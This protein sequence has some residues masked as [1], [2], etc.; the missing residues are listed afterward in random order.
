MTKIAVLDDWQHLA[1]SATD[2]SAVKAQAQVDF[3]YEPL[4]TG[5]DLAANLAGYDI[6]VA[7]RERARFDKT[8]IDAMTDLKLLSYTGPRNASVDLDACT[9]RGITVCNTNSFPLA[10]YDTAELALGHILALSRQI[11]LGDSEIRAGRF[12]SNMPTGLGLNQSVLGVIG[13]GRLGARLA[14]YALALEMKVIGWSPNLTAARAE[15][16]GVTL[17]TKEE[18]MAQSDVISI[19]MV[20]SDRS[21]GIV[22][23]ADIARMKPGAILV[24]T[25]RGP[26]VDEPALLEALN[27]RRIYAGLDVFAE[28]PL[29]VDHPLRSTPNT[30]LTPHLGYTT[31]RNMAYLYSQS[32]ENLLAW[33]AGKPI[34]VAN[35]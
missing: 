15:E 25:S 34:R 20:L 27:A 17:V 30:L 26:L 33:L 7:M 23:A 21:R 22:G 31:E 10:M 16:A 24:N 1:E 6:V 5:T 29:P 9:A 13:V 35:G 28:E 4:G 18:L 14:R 11:A 3:F 8:A 19:H 2:W 32:V 12:Q